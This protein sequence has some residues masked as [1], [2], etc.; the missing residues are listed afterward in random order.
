M[1]YYTSEVAPEWGSLALAIAARALEVRDGE[2]VIRWMG[3][4]P[5]EQREPL[6]G[7]E[8][9]CEYHIDIGARSVRALRGGLEGFVLKGAVLERCE[10]D[11]RISERILHTTIKDAST[12]SMVPLLPVVGGERLRQTA[13]YLVELGLTLSLAGHTRRGRALVVRHG[14]L[15]QQI[16]SY[17]NQVYDMDC[18]LLRLLL[19]Y[20]GLDPIEARK[21]EDHSM[22]L[23]PGRRGQICNAGL[24]VVHLLTRLK[25]EARDSDIAA[26]AE[27]L[28]RTRYLSLLIA[29]K[30]AA[31]YSRGEPLTAASL[32]TEAVEE[33]APCLSSMGLSV[34]DARYDIPRSLEDVMASTIDPS[35]EDPARTLREAAVERGFSGL[36]ES[37]YRGQLLDRLGVASDVEP[38]M[39]YRFLYGPR[40]ASSTPI[41]DKGELVEPPVVA[42]FNSNRIGE[43]AAVTVGEAEVSNAVKGFK[44]TYVT[45]DPTPTCSELA[46][47][48]SRLGPSTPGPHELADLVKVRHPVKLELIDSGRDPGRLVS[49]IYTQAQVTLYGVPAPLIVVDQRSR[50]TEWDASTIKSLLEALGRRVVP[51]STFIRDFS[52]RRKYMT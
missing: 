46:E 24:A 36:I 31:A 38:L 3:Q 52:T 26:V 39:V 11:G 1:L 40:E 34:Q 48:S 17:F 49:H 37:F 23:R 33:A 47:L 12:G 19:L 43:Y 5:G 35:T 18:S 42:S 27:D 14:A 50:V 32:F 30:T 15:L 45:P 51:Y 28:S 8:W 9:E 20:A 21:V 29:A 44:F 22:I 13:V 41:H 7:V 25:E 10:R 16:A 4:A 6:L 2:E